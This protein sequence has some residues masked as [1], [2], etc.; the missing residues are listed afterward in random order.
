MED[1]LRALSIKYVLLVS[2]GLP[3]LYY[4]FYFQPPNQ[5][6]TISDYEQ[7]LVEID[8]EIKKLERAKEFNNEADYNSTIDNI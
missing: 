8:A 3:V 6:K 4:L 7:Q 1:R 5:L 2:I